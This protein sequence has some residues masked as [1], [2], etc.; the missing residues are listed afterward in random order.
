M[1]V[2]FRKQQRE[3]PLLHIVGTVLEKVESFKFLGVHITDK[4]KWSTHTDSVVNLRRL[5]KFSLS[6][7]TLTNFYRCTIES[8][9]SGCITTWYGNCSAHNRKALQRVV[10]SAQRITG[11]NL[12]VLQDT[13]TT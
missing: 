3:Q 10:R 8:I 6:P 7:K 9:L 12:P 13:Y 5:K 11:G 2:D 4:L 1:I